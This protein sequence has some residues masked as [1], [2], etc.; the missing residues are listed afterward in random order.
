[1]QEVAMVVGIEDRHALVV[2]GKEQPR[3]SPSSA[4]CTTTNTA[5]LT[6]GR[7]I[8]TARSTRQR[9][10]RTAPHSQTRRRP[11]RPARCATPVGSRGSGPR[12]WLPG[13]G[14]CTAHTGTHAAHVDGHVADLVTPVLG[15]GVQPVGHDLGRCGLRPSRAG[16]AQRLGRRTRRATGRRGP[17]T[18]RC[19]GC[20]ESV[21]G[22]GGPSSMPSTGTGSGSSG[23][24]WAAWAVNAAIATGQDTPWSRAAC[25]TVVARSPT[26]APQ[27]ARSRVVSRCRAGTPAARHRRTTACRSRPCGS[28][29][30]VCA[31][32]AE[33][34]VRHRAG[35][36]VGWSPA[37]SARSTQ[38]GTRHSAPR[39]G[40]HGPGVPLGSRLDLPPPAA[41]PTRPIPEAASYPG[42][43]SWPSCDETA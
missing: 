14:R 12:R 17:P 29:T 31:T 11:P 5:A 10:R 16:P 34:A 35:R 4:C 1:V 40:S 43:S 27:E 9:G 15:A 30:A 24:T 19:R 26:A 20:G 21:A 3:Y 36:L 39:P 33:P 8:N 37:A 42:S 7:T 28:A 38:P 32:P 2:Q 25:T 13:A 22:H 23:N 41:R 6:G 18:R